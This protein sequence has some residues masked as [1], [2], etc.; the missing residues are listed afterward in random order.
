MS[1]C[2]IIPSSLGKY[3]C[4]LKPRQRNFWRRCRGGSGLFY[5][6]ISGVEETPWSSTRFLIT[7]LISLQL[8]FLPF[9]SCFPLPT[10]PICHFI[11]PLFRLPFSRQISCLLVTM[12]DFGMAETD[13]GRTPNIGRSGNL[14]AKTF[15]LGQGNVIGK[16]TIQEFFNCVGNLPLDDT[17]IL[18]RTIT[19][20]E[21]ISALVLKH[22]IDL[23]VP[24]LPWKDCFMSYML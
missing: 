5:V 2:C 10:S 7:N 4:R 3:R 11:R 9:A 22:E 21:A 13:D 17:H 20:A 14:D 19:Y 8:H 16:E 12:S 18:K 24:I 6:P 15:V 23:S 1:L